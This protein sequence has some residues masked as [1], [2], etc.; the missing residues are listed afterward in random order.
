MKDIYIKIWNQHCT[1]TTFWTFSGK[2]IRCNTTCENGGT[3]N[4]LE[5]CACPKD[6]YGRYC[7]SKLRELC[8]CMQQT[9]AVLKITNVFKLIIAKRILRLPNA[10]SNC[11]LHSLKN[12]ALIFKYF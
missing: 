3:C 5:Q 11:K 4:G 6:Y 9:S 7:S 12:L 1:E 8:M 2:I 10:V